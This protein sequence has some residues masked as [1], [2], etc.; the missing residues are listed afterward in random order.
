M[1]LAISSAVSPVKAP[2]QCSDRW[3]SLADDCISELSLWAW[4]ERA[5]ATAAVGAQS[6]SSVEDAREDT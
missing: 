1:F 3:V 5:V 6:A 2:V 4:E